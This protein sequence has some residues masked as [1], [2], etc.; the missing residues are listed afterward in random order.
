MDSIQSKII[1]LINSQVVRDAL[2]VPQYFTQNLEDFVEESVIEQYRHV[3][4]EE[5]LECLSKSLKP[6][7]SIEK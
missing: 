3:A 7:V 5:K 1:F 4:V 2:E 6:E